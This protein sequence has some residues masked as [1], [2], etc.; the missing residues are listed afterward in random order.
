LNQPCSIDNTKLFCDDETSDVA[1]NVK[2]EM[3]V[4]HK[5]ILKAQARE[6]Y[7]ICE[8]NDKENPM[9]IS[10]VD[11]GVFRIMLYSLYG[12]G[13]CPQDVQ[14]HSVSILKASGK[15]G[16]TKLKD[17][18]EVWHAKSI[19]FTV[20]NAVD[21]F[22]KADGSNYPIVK[23]AAKKFIL[24]HGEEIVE[25]ESFVGLNES[26]PFMREVLAAAFKNGNKRKRGS[27]SSWVGY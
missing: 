23:D 15:Y 1:F 22:M 21:E 4:A 20:D 25:S 16:F 14:E 5:G 18:V 11:E 9:V 2:G 10:D 6:F 26:L 17:E 13:L 7:E 24:E 12:G 19:K 27:V 8:E 3:I